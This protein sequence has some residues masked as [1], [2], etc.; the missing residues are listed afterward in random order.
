MEPVIIAI[1]DAAKAALAGLRGDRLKPGT[2]ARRLQNF[3]VQVPPKDRRKLITNGHVAFA[4]RAEQFAVL[5]TE[6][7]YTREVGL[8]WEDADSLGAEDLII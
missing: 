3:V 6:S 5:M 1:D 7:F 4:D 8:T 2:A